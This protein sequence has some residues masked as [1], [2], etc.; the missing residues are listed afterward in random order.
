MKKQILFLISLFVLTLLA[1]VVIGGVA[2]NLLNLT[3]KDE[4][5][6]I[7]L[8]ASAKSVLKLHISESYWKKD[9][10]TSGNK[11]EGYFCIHEREKDLYCPHFQLVSNY[12]VEKNI[13]IYCME[14]NKD[15]V[16]IRV[17]TI[18]EFIRLRQ[19]E[20]AQD[21]LQIKY[22]QYTADTTQTSVD[23]GKKTIS[24]D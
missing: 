15:G 16:C 19:T 21:F 4:T 11:V 14:K 17:P 2:D 6:N 3:P 24:L 9:L 22:N 13:D 23:F 20:I 8:P 18:D 5:L 1:G 12:E 10:I 7:N